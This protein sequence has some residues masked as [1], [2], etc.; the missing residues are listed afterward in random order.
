[1]NIAKMQLKDVPNFNLFHAIWMAIR[2]NIRR[3]GWI[4]AL[5]DFWEILR[6][7]YLSKSELPV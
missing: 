6:E 4:I 2:V 7:L 3:G 5:T 1:M